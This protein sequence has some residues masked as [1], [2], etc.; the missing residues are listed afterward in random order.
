MV[1]D[2]PAGGFIELGRIDVSNYTLNHL[3]TMALQLV[4]SFVD[5]YTACPDSAAQ[6]LQYTGGPGGTGKS[7]IIDALK[8]VFAA[9]AQ[10]H[11]LQITGTSDSAA[12]RI[13]GTTVY[14]ACGLDAHRRMWKQEMVLVVDEVSMLEEPLCT[15]LASTFN[16]SETARKSHL[17]GFLLSS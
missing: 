9:R 14:S 16:R 6:H 2:T 8:D 5:R 13:G 1:V 7:R 12:A 3:Q 4:C 17:D 11:L 10:R 15:T